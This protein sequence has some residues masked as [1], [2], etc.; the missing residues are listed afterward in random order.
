MAVAAPG[1]NVVP[2]PMFVIKPASEYQLSVPP[3]PAVA[4]RSAMA[5]PAQYVASVPAVGAA[6]M[7]FTVIVTVLALDSQPATVSV[8]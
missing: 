2:E 1:T 5:S 6:G 4:V 8:T 7:A 3:D